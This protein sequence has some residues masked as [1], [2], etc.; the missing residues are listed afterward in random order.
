VLVTDAATAGPRLVERFQPMTDLEVQLVTMDTPG[1]EQHLRGRGPTEGILL[2]LDHQRWA[3]CVRA[4]TVA[5]IHPGPVVLVAEDDGEPETDGE[6]G[7][8]A[9]VLLA[10]SEGSVLALVVPDQRRSLKRSDP[11]SSRFL[12]TLRV[13]NQPR[14]CEADA[15]QAID[16]ARYNPIGRRPG[17]REPLTVG[18]GSLDRVVAEVE[19]QADLPR[20]VELPPEAADGSISRSVLQLAALGVPVRFL[21]EPPELPGVS[22]RVQDVLARSHALDLSDPWTQELTSVGLRRA[23]IADHGRISGAGTRSVDRL[24]AGGLAPQGD[25]ASPAYRVPVT[26]LLASKRPE[27]IGAAVERVAL[28]DHRPLELVVA[29]H[30]FDPGLVP[31]PDPELPMTVLPVPEAALLGEVLNVATAA[32]SGAVLVKMDDDD[33]YGPSHVTDLLVALRFSGASVVGKAAEHIYLGALDVTVR[34]KRASERFGG[35]VAGG[36]IGCHRAVLADIGGWAPVPRA[37]DSRLLAAVE[38]AG[39]SVYQTHGF[40]FVLNR[41]GQRHTYPTGDSNYLRRLV[42]QR[43]GLDLPFAGIFDAAEPHRA[44]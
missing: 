30:G 14:V 13:S 42:A 25:P 3:E 18:S 26:V 8:G 12:S 15:W 10:T 4:L 20:F 2:Q 35:R 43:V 37:V 21:E 33:H 22:H 5:R 29:T 39:G 24:E 16:L 19:A 27:L 28:Q 11:A 36:A 17:R 41:H 31:R 32:A 44:S 38:L 23:A 6:E 1:W 9:E 34:R 40:G 7:E